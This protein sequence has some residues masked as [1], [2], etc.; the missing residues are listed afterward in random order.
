MLRIAITGPESTGKST[1][2]EQL[3]KYFSCAF[4]PEYARTYLSKKNGSYQKEDLLAIAREQF[5]QN[6]ETQDSKLVICDTEITVIKVWS[7]F[8]YGSCDEQILQLLNKQKF[9]HYFLCDIDIP[10]END[11]L[12]EH[13]EKREE[14]LTLYKKELS[15]QP[16]T[17]VSGNANQRLEQVV[18]CLEKLFH[19]KN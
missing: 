2:S 14:L 6:N 5:K 18:S 15:N 7:D 13:P 4:V 19:L 10:W 8:K 9:D 12:R 11:P 16:Y 17:L 1:L 3:A